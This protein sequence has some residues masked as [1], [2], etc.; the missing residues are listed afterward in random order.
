MSATLTLHWNL[1]W[2]VLKNNSNGGSKNLGFLFLNTNYPG[3]FSKRVARDSLLFESNFGS[4]G[5]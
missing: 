5:I 2:L 1:T 4:Q 3:N